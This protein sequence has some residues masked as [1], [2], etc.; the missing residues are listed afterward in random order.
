LK[1]GEDAC[2]SVWLSPN[3]LK[4]RETKIQNFQSATKCDVYSSQ[5]VFLA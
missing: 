4:T 1:R 2:L 5:R 3:M